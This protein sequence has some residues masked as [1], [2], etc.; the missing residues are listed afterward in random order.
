MNEEQQAMEAYQNAGVDLP[1]LNEPEAPQATEEP[2][3]DEPKDQE[4]LKETER[5]ERKRSIY[6]EYKEK[7]AELK[8]EKELREQAE[9]ERDDL[10]AKLEA[11]QTAET[12]QEK[13]EAQD[14]LT[15]F[16]QKV[17]ADPTAL[18]EMQQL[19]TKDIKPTIDPQLAARLDKFEA[20]QKDNAQVIEKQMFEEEFNKSV[21]SLKALI[22]NASDAEM[23]A[24]KAELDRLSHTQEYHDKDLE[25]IAWKHKDSL[26]ALVSPKK[27]G[28]E[29][30]G[31]VDAAEE[32]FD[33]DPNADYSRL[34]PKER[35]LWEAGYNRMTKSAELHKDAD[36]RLVIL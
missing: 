34:S 16:A 14:E 11:V 4:P 26:S 18:R 35:E 3:A 30:K 33:F 9:R 6:D 2:K 5:V 31:R 19:F 25:Y 23:Q 13:Q 27:R 32:S 36:G 12:P 1:E 17:N 22:P 29:P 15:A 21:P 24:V 7:K 20:W 28:L 8:S 10:K